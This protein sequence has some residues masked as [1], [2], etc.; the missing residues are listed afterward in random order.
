MVA[1]TS[2]ERSC[3]INERGF[4]TARALVV[5]TLSLGMSLC[6]LLSGLGT[7]F[8][9]G[10]EKRVSLLKTQLLEVGARHNQLYIVSFVDHFDL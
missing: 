4:W 5:A 8:F 7:L 6:A 3:A 10:N 1:V 2:S 9:Q